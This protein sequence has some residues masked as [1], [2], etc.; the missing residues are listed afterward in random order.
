MADIIQLLPDSIANQIAAGEVIQR[1]A[2]VVK[3]LLENSIDAGSKEIKLI[4]K[5]AGKTLIQ[6]LDNGKG[7]S[8]TDARMSFERHATSK[9]KEAND[10]FTISTMGFRGEALASIAA[11]AQ[12]EM[13]TKQQNDDLGTRILIE[14]STV[15]KQEPAELH[16]GTSFSVK[17]L[18]Y[19]VPAR[20]KFLK[21]DPVEL[22]HIIDQFIR[23]SLAHSDIFF[24]MYHNGNELYHLPPGNT[25][26][27]IVGI[28]GK[29]INDKLVPV[30]EDTDIFRLS[31]FISKPEAAK[32]KKGDQYIFVNNRF[33]KSNYL[34][35]A[36]RI[37][38]DELIPKEN[39]AF[40]VIYLEMSPSMIDINVHPTKTEIKFEE[41]RLIYNFVKVAVK[42]AL[43]AYTVT[44][45]LD[46][47]IDSNFDNR[48][49][50]D[51]QPHDMQ[52]ETRGN[53]SQAPKLTQQQRDNINSWE[54][55]YQD[56]QANNNSTDSQAIT[57]ESDLMDN[58][59]KNVVFGSKTRKEP[60]Q[61]HNTYIVNQIKSGFLLIDQ[62]AAH[63]RILYEGY[64]DQL[65]QHIGMSQKQLF[66][67]SLELSP[68]DAQLMGDILH[69]IN[70]IG[71]EIEP[72][73]KNT[74]IMHGLPVGVSHQS[75]EA[76]IENLLHQYQ[77][78]MELQLGIDRNIAR[79]MASAASIKR[80]K[81]LSHDEMHEL[82]DQLF[83]CS[84]PYKSPNGRKCFITVELDDLLKRF[85]S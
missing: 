54:D 12:V 42:H 14:G 80:G 83:A 4:I 52:R 27:R 33:I 30:S 35:H 7:M 64:L 36:I 74:F 79:S 38:Y 67:I 28:F 56:L 10:L 9:I 81:Q 29:N 72:F 19:N 75:P 48:M 3:E 69:K 66:P 85:T 18:F 84:I 22:R 73:G 47:N 59:N 71:F 16:V 31:G 63:E 23:V 8:A 51:M 44:P 2:S 11:I 58:D 60:Y 43:G 45:S 57:V 49:R 53:V 41:E 70:A 6:V 1:P 61:I 25:R 50:H 65:N 37:A 39:Y 82:I 68:I 24:T 77:S 32:K 46:F 17:N 34:N 5:D 21:S 62:Q 40:Y 15:K 13:I 26:Q 78:N 20:R 76:L 55:L